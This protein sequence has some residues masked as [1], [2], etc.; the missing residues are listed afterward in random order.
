MIDVANSLGGGLTRAMTSSAQSPRVTA[1]L[2]L[3]VAVG[4]GC[5]GSEQTTGDFRFS[6]LQFVSDLLAFAQI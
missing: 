2:S 4:S 5:G 3:I 6:H 1:F